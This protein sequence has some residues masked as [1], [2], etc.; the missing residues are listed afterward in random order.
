MKT[1]RLSGR[2]PSHKGWPS[3]SKRARVM[4]ERR[5]GT[6]AGVN[7]Q[8]TAV[9]QTIYASLW[10]YVLR[11]MGTWPLGT[12]SVKGDEDICVQ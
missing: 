2:Q 11:S 1:R 3:L 4:D 12:R 10:H 9:M 8:G 7:R 6:S 5:S